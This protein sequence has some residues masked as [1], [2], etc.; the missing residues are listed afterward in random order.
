MGKIESAYIHGRRDK[1]L[2]RKLFI[3]SL[4]Y[5]KRAVKLFKKVILNEHMQ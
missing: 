3:I 2:F 5:K 4:F 1:I